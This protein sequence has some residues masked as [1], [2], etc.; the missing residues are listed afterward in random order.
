MLRVTYHNLCL[1][2][3][4]LGWNKRQRICTRCQHEGGDG[5]S[6]GPKCPQHIGRHVHRSRIWKP[7][8]QRIFISWS[9][10]LTTTNSKKRQN[11]KYNSSENIQLIQCIH[12]N[13]QFQFWTH[14][15]KV[16]PNFRFGFGTKTNSK[17]SLRASSYSQNWQK[18]FWSTSIQ[19]TDLRKKV[20]FTKWKLSV[21]LL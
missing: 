4:Y 7:D 8:H 2:R 5:G 3:L 17:L 11:I 13:C 12:Y 10:T 18:W 20:Y 19:K 14:E 15:T 21:P 6:Q 9:T 1:V 16:R